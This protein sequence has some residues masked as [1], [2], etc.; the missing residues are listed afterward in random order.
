M[1]MKINVK[2]M[3]KNMII[4]LMIYMMVIN[5]ICENLKISD[6]VRYLSDIIVFFLFVYLICN[7]KKIINNKNTKK[8]FLVFLLFLCMSFVGYILNFYSPTLYF[9]G[10]RNLCR[11][12][13][14]FF[15]TIIAFE[16]NDL[17]KIYNIYNIIFFLNILLVCYQYFYLG[18]W[19]DRIGGT[20]RLIDKG[21]NAG[22][23]FL[24]I[25]ENIYAF[26][27]FLNKKITFFRL[28]LII[29]SSMLISA[30]AELKAF[31][32]LFILIIFLSLILNRMSF[33]TILIS[34]MSILG[35]YIGILALAYIAPESAAILNMDGIMHYVA[36]NDHGYSSRDDISRGRAFS[37][38][39]EKF[40]DGHLMNKLFGYGLGNCDVSSVRIFCSE[41]YREHKYLNY[42]WFM[43]AMLYIETGYIG[44]V[45]YILFFIVCICK[46]W[47]FRKND[48]ENIFVYNSGIIVAIICIIMTWYNASLRN[49]TS[50][51]IY[52]SLAL[53]FIEYYDLLKNNEKS[54]F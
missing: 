40:F 4:F 1:I 19:A 6:S 43:H 34:I 53:P 46:Y 7:M 28:I 26:S 14:V 21:G 35:L 16:K 36:G 17:K 23:L 10:I 27:E 8:V 29:I 30:I 33:K 49:D 24:L 9:W 41:F 52:I 22:L 31:F 5:C 54:K 38:I 51:F 39:N 20:F 42:I 3:V 15:T 47:E 13:I 44:Y 2:K 45:I 32:V 12:F 18:Y 25:I 48:K 50:F 37:Q 11:F